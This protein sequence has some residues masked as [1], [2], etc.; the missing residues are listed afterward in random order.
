MIHLTTEQEGRLKGIKGMAQCVLSAA[1]ALPEHDCP[2]LFNQL[3]ELEVFAR[4]LELSAKRLRF[5]LKNTGR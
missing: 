1:E 4:A 2:L 5:S 3:D